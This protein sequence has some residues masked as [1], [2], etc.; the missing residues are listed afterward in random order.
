MA[1]TEQE[2]IEYLALL[3]TEYKEQLVERDTV[4]TTDDELWYYIKKFFKLSIS[5]V[6]VCHNH[7]SPFQFVADVFFQRQLNVLGFASRDSGKTRNMSIVHQLNSH[8]KK[9]CDSCSVG[10]IELQA[11]KCYQ[12]VQEYIGRTGWYRD[13][14]E[15]SR[16][17]DTLFKNGS[18]IV[19]LPGTISSVNSPHPQIAMF[20]EVE[21]SEWNIF[22]EFL[23]MAHSHDGIQ[24]Q[25]ILISTRKFLSGT[26]QRIL[27]EGKF[28]VYQYCVFEVA[29]K[30]TEMSCEGCLEVVNGKWAT[31][32]A[33][34]FESVCKGRMR[35]SDGFI[36]KVDILNRFETLDR[37]TWETQQE[38]LAPERSG[39][40]H[41]WFDKPTEGLEVDQYVGLYEGIDWGADDPSV[42][43]WGQKVGQEIRIFDEVYQ[44]GL[45]VQDFIGILQGKRLAEGY[46]D[47]VYET[48]VDPSGKSARID[49]ENAGIN[50]SINFARDV[51]YGI[52]VIRSLGEKGLIKIDPKCVNLIRELGE[53]RK[54]PPKDGGVKYTYT[55]DDHACDALRYLVLGVI[56]QE[57]GMPTIRRAGGD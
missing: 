57:S 53:Y 40:V 48:F 39:L 1:L 45:G 27:D 55:G 6:A 25:N 33:R 35:R 49:F 22:Q 47:Y 26:M 24:A 14:V 4:P 37:N 43:L 18:K 34:T 16:I 44:S 31:G 46:Q 19:I 3:E 28:K 36:A 52:S 11:K 12:Y 2:E 50:T 29:E 30:C 7:T 17:G 38:C 56:A 5:R 21:L 8:F 41:A 13:T 9:G 23:N 51:E 54:R 32:T 10:A 42:C 20:D 15:C